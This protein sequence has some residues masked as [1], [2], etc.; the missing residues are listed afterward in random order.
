MRFDMFSAPTASF[1]DQLLA[2]QPAIGPDGATWKL[3]RWGQKGYQYWGFSRTAP[4][5]ITLAWTSASGIREHQD[6]IAAVD[7]LEK[8]LVMWGD[9]WRQ[10][11][12]EQRL[13][14]ARVAHDLFRIRCAMPEGWRWSKWGLLGESYSIQRPYVRDEPR[15]PMQT[16]YP[17]DLY[18]DDGHAD[19]IIASISSWVWPPVAIAIVEDDIDEVVAADADEQLGMVL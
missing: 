13:N 4:G 17:H 3:V 7:E 1:R 5:D 16:I 15:S 14:R 8:R 2:D 12:E 19:R 6:R 18:R 10:R 11:D 9:G